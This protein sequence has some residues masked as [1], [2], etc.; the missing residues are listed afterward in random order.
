MPL[1]GQRFE[2]ACRYAASMLIEK[3]M[4]SYRG[5][6]IEERK[7]E[8]SRFRTEAYSQRNRAITAKPLLCELSLV[9]GAS[10]LRN[11]NNNDYI[12]QKH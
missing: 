3:G 9:G 1:A 7:H 6:R 5:A 4:K 12:Q 8:T 2:W 11:N 10:P